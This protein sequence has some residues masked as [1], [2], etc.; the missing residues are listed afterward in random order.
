[1]I[2]V[3]HLLFLLLHFFVCRWFVGF[4]LFVLGKGRGGC[5]N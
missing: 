5:D 4:C 2:N 3:L 1:M